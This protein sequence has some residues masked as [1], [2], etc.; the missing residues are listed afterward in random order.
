MGYNASDEQQV[1]DLEQEAQNARNQE[2]EDI[3]TILDTPHGVRF[4]KRLFDIGCMFQTTF[5]GNSNSFFKEGHRNFALMFF[6]DVCEACP[7]K[8][9][10]LLVKKIAE[11]KA[12]ENVDSD[13]E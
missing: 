5:T 1:K 10:E 3:K 2:L 4:F 13:S 8:I 11:K 6:N 9:S 12:E 7:N